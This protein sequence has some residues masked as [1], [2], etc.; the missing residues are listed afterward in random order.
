MR[1]RRSL[2]A[3]LLVSL[4]VACTGG[5]DGQDADNFTPGEETP[6]TAAGNRVTDGTG[7]ALEAHY[8]P[9]APGSVRVGRR[10]TGS[11]I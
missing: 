7:A 2:A 6:T 5:D 1:V 10:P 11:P 9:A 4:V 3:M 8:D